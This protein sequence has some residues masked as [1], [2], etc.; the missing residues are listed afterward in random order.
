MKVATRCAARCIWPW[1]ELTRIRAPLW[2]LVGG[3]VPSGCNPGHDL[4]RVH[5]KKMPGETSVF[6]GIAGLRC[7]FQHRR[8]DSRERKRFVRF[9]WYVGHPSGLSFHA[10]KPG[11][12]RA[13]HGRVRGADPISRL[14]G[15]LAPD[16]PPLSPGKSDPSANMVRSANLR[17]ASR[18]SDPRPTQYQRGRGATPVTRSTQAIAK[19]IVAEALDLIEHSGLAVPQPDRRQRHA[20][21]GIGLHH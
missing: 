14:S 9:A 8:P 17:P 11:L 3:P 16:D 13:V 20:V 5:G 2:T 1:H 10:C 21:E 12:A 6:R 18:P 7:P 15:R 4:G 19:R